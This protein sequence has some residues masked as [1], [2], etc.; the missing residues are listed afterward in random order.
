MSDNDSGLDT[1]TEQELIDARR[2]AAGLGQTG[3]PWALAFSGGGIRS[4]TFCLGLARALARNGLFSRFDYLSTVSGGGYI[5]S[6]IGRLYS[7]KATAPRVSEGLQD[8]RSLFLW[9][10][11]SNG[12]FLL[13]AGFGDAI[14]AGASYVRGTLATHIEVGV[15]ALLLSCLAILPHMLMLQFAPLLAWGAALG[16]PWWSLLPLAVFGGMALL[17]AYWFARDDSERWPWDLL[18]CALLFLLSMLLYRCALQHTGTDTRY[19]A[20]MAV[21][22]VLLA[23]PAGGLIYLLYRRGSQWL[24]TLNPRLLDHEL[25]PP[26]IRL[27]LTF[28]F[29]Q[30][31]VLSFLAFGLGLMDLL[32][33]MAASKLNRLTAELYATG[34]GFTTALVLALRIVV[35]AIQKYLAEPG[36]GSRLMLLLNA[37]GLLLTALVLTLWLIAAQWFV[38]FL[39]LSPGDALC[40]AVKMACSLNPLNGLDTVPGRWLLLTLALL[41]YV[42]ITGPNADQVNRSSL[43]PFYRSRLARSY[44]SVGNSPDHP[45][46]EGD[47]RFEVSPLEK[48][49]RSSTEQVGKVGEYRLGDDVALK[50]YRPYESGG[51]IHLINCCINQTVDDRTG[52]FNAD[53]KGVNLTV[54]ALG[55]EIGTR[56]P[57]DDG[58][59]GDTGVAQWV[60]ISGAAAGPG[61]GSE[62]RFGLSALS[63]LTGV[64]LGFWWTRDRAVYGRSLLGKYS[65]TL[66][67][68]FGKF[69]GLSS[70][71]LYL[72]DGGHF[73]NTGIYTLLKRKPELIVAADCG[74]DPKYLFSD[75]E[76]L[77]R[78]ARID[79]D[80][81]IDFISPA[82]LKDQPEL[83][84]CLPLFGTPDSITAEPEGDFLMFAKVDYGNGEQGSIIFVK[85]RRVRSLPL[86]LAGYSDR[87]LEF[88]QQT[89]ADQFFD[90]AQ[91]ESYCEL[92]KRL[93]L[94]ITPELLKLLPLLQAG[95]VAETRNLAGEILAAER[96]ESGS[97]RERFT[98]TVGKTLGAGA[99]ASLLVV[100]W[101]AWQDTRTAW[102]QARDG[103]NS[104]VGGLL[105][106]V[107]EKLDALAEGSEV[108]IKPALAGWVAA[109]EGIDAKHGS[110]ARN[111]A[112]DQALSAIYEACRPDTEGDEASKDDAQRRFCSTALAVL[113][114]P[115][116]SPW[117]AA[118]QQYWSPAMLFASEEKPAIAACAQQEGVRRKLV[119]HTAGGQDSR[120][121]GVVSLAVGAGMDVRIRASGG[122]SQALAER[123]LDAVSFP[124]PALLGLL[125]DGRC[126]GELR[127]R[128]LEPLGAVSE[129]VVPGFDHAKG[130]L[131]LWLPPE[132]RQAAAATPEPM[133]P[134]EPPPAIVMSA[135]PPDIVMSAPPPSW[136]PGTPVR[137]PA[138]DSDDA[139]AAAPTEY[140]VY[141][142]FQGLLT[143]AQI[144]EYRRQLQDGKTTVSFRME[145][146]ER[147]EGRYGNLVKYFNRNNAAAAEILASSTTDFFR[148]KGC[149]LTPALQVGLHGGKAPPNS[150]EVW[151]SPPKCT[152]WSS[153]SKGAS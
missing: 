8:D 45:T 74:A 73:D 50:L 62:S 49:E 11:R 138:G 87:D 53:R 69:P 75:I 147:L 150:L 101:Q 118:H 112:H 142:Q 124:Q 86:D 110:V 19:W 90:E 23:G 149:E 15:L 120:I 57:Y 12:R 58:V 30:M 22:V 28:W 99:A 95:K 82:S 71:P 14:S 24:R 133:A 102:V 17:A 33:W 79:Y 48:A 52:N 122:P 38:Y 5:G 135:P 1:R 76:N 54:S 18:W 81:R 3:R 83:K 134:V 151:I 117:S 100:G 140:V 26:H 77:I 64:R 107:R 145:P 42:L 39:P 143:R 109:I 40:G 146:A 67:E 66:R 132:Q 98:A 127:E 78:K 16:N 65:A 152:A 51:P 139:S 43:H 141:V 21:A 106:D 85:P 123:A 94:N 153:P 31:I 72:S 130:T 144:N 93:G 56:A 25:T 131:H 6:A 44:V 104:A 2:Q 10:L 115:R 34:V 70:S 92:G 61:M 4:A 9:W 119:I 32:T 91:W 111:Q 13:P 113:S 63:F 108:K 35:P 105:K 20:L 97:R 137:S 46:T 37:G 36:Q 148:K 114:S 126:L 96:R 59:I 89:T 128:L 88:P 80:I 27:R 68:W 116:V 7:K 84:D 55:V 103:E 129:I 60:A 125:P 29:S 136:D 47:R 121:E 41:A